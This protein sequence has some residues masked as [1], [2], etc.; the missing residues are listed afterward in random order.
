MGWEVGGRGVG[1]SGGGGGGGV[2]RLGVWIWSYTC[3][4]TLINETY[5]ADLKKSV[6]LVLIEEKKLF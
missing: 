1:G 2:V 3:D 5:V 6:L 4:L